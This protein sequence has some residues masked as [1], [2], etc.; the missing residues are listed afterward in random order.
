MTDSSRVNAKLNKETRSERS[1]AP[2]FRDATLC[3]LD[4]IYTIE[5]ASF[6]SPWSRAAL[7]AEITERSWSRFIV[8]TLHGQLVGYMIYWVVASEIHLLNLAVDPMWRRCGIGTALLSHLIDQAKE[9]KQ[10]EIF[11]E[12][13]VSNHSARRL[14]R[15]FD[16]EPLSVRRGYYADTGEDALV[17]SLIMR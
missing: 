10:T 5:E 4:S 3:D 12:V 11:L 17:M 14:Y 8:A 2:A 7:A 1:F 15:R 9:K 13:R 6:S 16:F